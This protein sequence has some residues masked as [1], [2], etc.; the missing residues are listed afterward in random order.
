[1]TRQ[2]CYRSAKSPSAFNPVATAD[3][4]TGGEHSRIN[5]TAS[6]VSDTSDLIDAINTVAPFAVGVAA[7]LLNCR[8]MRTMTGYNSLENIAFDVAFMLVGALMGGVLGYLL[9]RFG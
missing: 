2:G 3:R 5:R 9:G 8:P 4:V 6:N 7:E 1:M